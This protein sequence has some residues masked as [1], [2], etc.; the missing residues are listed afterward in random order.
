MFGSALSFGYTRVNKVQNVP[1]F[2]EAMKQ[3]FIWLQ[4][5]KKPTTVV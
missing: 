1:A 5:I 4:V 3:D 2:M